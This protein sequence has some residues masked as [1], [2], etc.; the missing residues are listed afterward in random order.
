MIAAVIYLERILE[1]SKYELRICS[2]NWH[3]ILWIC[4]VMASKVWDDFAMTNSDYSQIFK[5]MSLPILNKMEETIL[6]LFNYQL[7]LSPE[8]FGFYNNTFTAM[9]LD[10]KLNNSIKLLNQQKSISFSPLSSPDDLKTFKPTRPPLE[11][12]NRT[13]SVS[14][15]TI[16]R[17]E[18]EADECE[19][20]D[21]D[22]EISALPL[23]DHQFSFS[24]FHGTNL[25][26][27]SL[28]P[29]ISEIL[30]RSHSFP[31]TPNDE[32]KF[33]TSISSCTSE[34][35]RLFSEDLLKLKDPDD[36]T[37]DGGN[38]DIE[39]HPP[40]D[41]GDGAHLDKE[42]KSK[43]NVFQFIHKNKILP[44]PTPISVSPPLG[45]GRCKTSPS[46]T[47]QQAFPSKPSRLLS[48]FPFR[49]FFH[50][51]PQHLAL[52][53]IL[54]SLPRRPKFFHSRVHMDD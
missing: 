25:Q 32:L 1:S 8:E 16:D 22:G 34:R 42:N 45:Q 36:E 38:A 29:V 51:S 2:R 26:L 20:E 4:M 11:S 12:S 3:R 46:P 40:I 14:T 30:S 24:R 54:D 9:I 44:T 5:N 23:L 39:I 6:S 13:A 7:Q 19:D 28:S 21:D 53:S 41:Q 17:D 37:D 10:A 52:P 43:R 48:K 47:K 15:T 31:L 18:G 33:L 50:S 49:Q 35:K 27:S